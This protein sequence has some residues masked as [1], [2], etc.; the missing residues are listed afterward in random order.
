MLAARH[1]IA[2]ARVTLLPLTTGLIGIC[3]TGHGSIRTWEFPITKYHRKA[4]K[5]G[6][7]EMGKTHRRISALLLFVPQPLQL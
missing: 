5:G 7:G 2:F 6:Y 4:W 3:K 1:P